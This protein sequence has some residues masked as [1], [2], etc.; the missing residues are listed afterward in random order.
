VVHAVAFLSLCSLA[1]CSLSSDHMSCSVSA[2]ECHD[3]ENVSVQ[4]RT[5]I[6]GVCRGLSGTFSTSMMCPTAN[7]VGGCREETKNQTQTKWYYTPKT[8]ADVQARCS[9]KV[10]DGAGNPLE[11]VDL[12]PAPVDG[13]MCSP[14]GGAPSTITFRNV[15]S[16]VVSVYWVR[17]A[18]TET[19]YHTISPTE[20]K[21]Q[22]TYAGHIWR[23]RDG[24]GGPPVRGD[25]VTPEGSSTL[26]INSRRVRWFASPRGRAR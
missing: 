4:V 11:G 23:F 18:C 8:L 1:G 2:E 16:R 7:R 5:G 14:N 22:S 24:I 15:G 25:Y 10:V 12:A 13:G 17:Q 19:L 21:M 20:T 9:G 26:D 6:E 3:F